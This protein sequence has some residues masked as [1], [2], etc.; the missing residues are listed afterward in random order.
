[1][2]TSCTLVVPV[3]NRQKCSPHFLDI[4]YR[5]V[6]SLFSLVRDTTLNLARA[7]EESK[8]NS[9]VSCSVA[10]GP[11]T[12]L[13]AAEYAEATRWIVLYIPRGKSRVDSSTPYVYSLATQRCLQPRDTAALCHRQRAAP[14]PPHHARAG[15]HCRLCRRLSSSSSPPNRA[16]FQALYGRSLYRDPFFH[17]VRPH[18]ILMPRRICTHA[19]SSSARSRPAT[20]S[21]P[22]P[23]S[24]VMPPASRATSPPL[25][26]FGRRSTQLAA[27][28]VAPPAASSSSPQT[29]PASSSPQTPS[30]SAPAKP[31]PYDASAVDTWDAWRASPVPVHEPAGAQ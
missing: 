14:R 28:L 11:A 25:G 16:D 29:P 6:T 23:H 30:A 2:S 10:L 4:G 8:S 18:S 22:S 21:S 26:S 17:F 24:C 5:L 20:R 1:M 3:C 9:P 12:L 19:A 15:R 31:P 13:Q 7:L 27:Y